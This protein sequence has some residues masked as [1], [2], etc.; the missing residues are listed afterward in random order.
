[1]VQ[2]ELKCTDMNVICL[3]TKAFYSLIDEVMA[4]V[5]PKN[6]PKK[7]LSTDEAMELLQIKSKTTLQKLRDEAL[8]RFSQ[9]QKKIII[10][11]RESI[12]EYLEN[13]V[14]ETF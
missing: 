10:Y 4:R 6:E 13:N 7:W 14:K 11:D 2:H 3:E 5:I 9:P 12:L 1:M 8:I